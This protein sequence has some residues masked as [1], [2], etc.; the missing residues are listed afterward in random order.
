MKCATSACEVWFKTT[1]RFFNMSIAKKFACSA[2]LS[3]K[4]MQVWRCGGP[5]PWRRTPDTAAL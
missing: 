5:W 3:R 4:A 1:R 2:K